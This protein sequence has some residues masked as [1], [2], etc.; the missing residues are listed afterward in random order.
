MDGKLAKIQW[1]K[2]EN[3]K[4][5]EPGLENCPSNTFIRRSELRKKI[6]SERATVN[7]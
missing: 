6:K 3:N 5:L 1:D 7:A 4:L 2:V